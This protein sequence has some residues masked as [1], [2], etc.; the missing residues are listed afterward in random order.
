MRGA[1]EGSWG[2]VEI[3]KQGIRE[4]LNNLKFYCIQIQT[5]VSD[6]SLALGSELGSG[7][8]SPWSRRDHVPQE[9]GC[10]AQRR[11]SQFT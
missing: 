4:Q 9:A 5:L 11:S 2:L 6:S 8:S 7:I 10:P 1:S 3:S